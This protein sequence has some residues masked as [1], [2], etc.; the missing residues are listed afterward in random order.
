VIGPLV[1][2]TAFGVTDC[3]KVCDATCIPFEWEIHCYWI[4]LFYCWQNVF[5]TKDERIKIG[6][7][8][9]AKLL[10]RYRHWYIYRQ[11]RYDMQ[12]CLCCVI[13]YQ[14]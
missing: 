3:V 14:S 1:L 9:I 8:G 6:D 11:C 7:F 13:F 2:E 5:L 12:V 4:M 10:N